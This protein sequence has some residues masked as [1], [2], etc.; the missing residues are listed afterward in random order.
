MEAHHEEAHGHSLAED[1]AAMMRMSAS[2]RQS[3]RWLLAGAS[4]LPVLGCGGGSSATDTSAASTSTSSGTGTGTGT[5]TDSTGSTGSAGSCAVIPEE[6]GGPYPADGTNSNGTGSGT[7]SVLNLAGVVR[8]DIRSSFNG[9]TAVAAGVPLTIKLQ[10]VNANGS[11]AA[12]PGYAVYLWHCDRDGNYS[13]Y[14]SGVTDQNYLRGVQEADSSGNVTFS[15]IFPGCYSGRMPHVH[16]EVYPTLAKSVSAANRVKT[17]QFTFP[18]ATLNEVYA[19]AGY[20]ASVRNLAQTSYAA[21]LVFGDGT[22]LQMVAVTGNVTDGYVV[23]L[24]VGVSA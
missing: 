11:C 15:S 10:I 23:T 18:M 2:R 13:L 17:S 4:A 3:L 8:S 16:F 24:T 21:D 6:T 20:S 9:A 12:L 5:S 19:S 1:L 22:S 14:S 7:T